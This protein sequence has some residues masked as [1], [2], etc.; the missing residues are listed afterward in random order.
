[1]YF[2]SKT[3]ITVKMNTVGTVTEVVKHRY[4]LH[5]L[6]VSFNLKILTTVFRTP[7][8]TLIH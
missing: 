7:H 5:K 3:E 1:M 6:A 8:G 2:A 4:I